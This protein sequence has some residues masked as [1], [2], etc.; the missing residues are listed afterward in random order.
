MNLR[1]NMHKKDIL[2]RIGTNNQTLTRFG[3]LGFI[4]RAC[5]FRGKELGYK[6]GH[7]YF[8]WPLK[9]EFTREHHLKRIGKELER[10]IKEL[11]CPRES[12]LPIKFIENKDVV[13]LE[14]SEIINLIDKGVFYEDSNPIYSTIEDGIIVR[15]HQAIFNYFNKYYIE[16]GIRPIIKL[17]KD[18][19]KEKYILVHTRNA[20]NS[21]L[22]NPDINSYRKV[23]GIIK[24]KYPTYKIY[25]CGEE[26][27]DEED[28]DFF[29]KY[30]PQSESFN[31]FIKLVNNSSLYIGCTSGPIEYARGLGIPLIE[32]DIPKRA[33]DDETLDHYYSEEYWEKY[34]HGIY[35]RNI[36]EHIDHN[37]LL[38]LFKGDGIDSIKICEFVDKWFRV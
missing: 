12:I 18:K 24:E 33:W 1:R 14:F 30:I 25:R 11:K 26:F 19:I 8:E 38:Q 4:Y 35:G 37:L 28:F 16:Y 2:F 17:K 32:L 36:D 10:E 15:R 22:R 27:T 31:D 20:L 9:M 13:L 34:M 5:Y 3:E 21:I 23:L 6:D 29:D 7:I